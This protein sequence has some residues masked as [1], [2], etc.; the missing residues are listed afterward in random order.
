MEV[1]LSDLMAFVNFLPTASRSM[2]S[3][4]RRRSI[5]LITM[6]GAVA[7]AAAIVECGN[8][9]ASLRVFLDI[10]AALLL[11]AGGV[12]LCLLIEVLGRAYDEFDQLRRKNESL[13]RYSAGVG[14]ILT[15]S[16]KIADTSASVAESWGYPAAELVGK[17]L[18]SII[19]PDARDDF[20]RLLNLSLS[21]PGAAVTGETQIYNG[22]GAVRPVEV[23][24]KNL[25]DQPDIG[26]VMV[27]CQDIG[28]RK[29]LLAQI[30]F[31]SFHDPLTKLPNRSLFTER[32][33]HALDRTN[34]SKETVGIVFLD[35]DNFKVVN[36]SLGHEAGDVLLLTVASRLTACARPGDTVARI[37]GDEF[38]LILED[39]DDTSM[40][41]LAERIAAL[42]S[43]PVIIDGREFYMAASMGIALSA[44]EN[45]T[46]TDMM[47]HADTAMH[48]AKTSGKGRT[49]V[50]DLSMNA[51]A[52]DRFE[53][54]T[55]L[56][57]ALENDELK[58]FYQPIV[59][60]RTGYVTEVEALVRWQH[61]RRGLISPIHF[62][63]LAEETGLIV[64]LGR[65]VLGEACRQACAWKLAMPDRAAVAVGVNL[66]TRQLR[67]PNLV[68][69]IA[70]TLAE[71]GLEPANL[72]L[73][74]TESSM[75]Q[76][77]DITIGRLRA[78]RRLGVRLAVDDF[79]TGYSSMSYLSSLPI[80]TLKIDRSFITRIAHSRDDAAIV[81]AIVDLAKS[82]KLRIIC[83]GIETVEQ[84]RSLQRLGCD[85]GQ[86]YLFARPLSQID[87]WSL[88]QTPDLKLCSPAGEFES[89]RRSSPS[90]RS[91]AA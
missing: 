42:I 75:L 11:I 14:L 73:E 31:Q 17:P 52:V 88:I 22:Q 63:P 91:D 6:L 83:E 51:R 85:D 7:A 9:S 21:Q 89:Y 48:Q 5:V 62:V 41:G 19:E 16:G 12:V 59:D 61:P 46:V 33:E 55:S 81:R 71:T 18:Y 30:S 38:A 36:D 58:V 50:F 84:L 23:I 28:E 44:D 34:R 39:V 3:R 66:S 8:G 60:L 87:A 27:M 40:L 80:D 49:A 20:E 54:E 29:Q 77:A 57:R 37:G 13:L 76:D 53:M 10:I 68:D 72:K 24:L 56:H 65:W 2:Q 82:L 90:N 26:G 70:R 67:E 15:D 1:E 69:D 4:Q 78:I 35:L 43:D 74:I 45:H 32:L 79:G 64:P 25:L 47:R 86:G